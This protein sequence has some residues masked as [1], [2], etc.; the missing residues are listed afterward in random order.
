MN[1]IPCTYRLSVKAIIKDDDGRILLIREKDGSWEF[2]G[3][4]LEHGEKSREGLAREIAEETGLRV[5]SVSENPVA[6]WTI[7]KEVGSPVLKWFAFVA[8][9]VKVAGAF[10]PDQNSDEAEEAGYFSQSEAASLRLHENTKPYF[11]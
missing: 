4:G 6:F 9:L 5:V 1:D 11:S 10:R 3:G 7:Y 8:Y 2:P